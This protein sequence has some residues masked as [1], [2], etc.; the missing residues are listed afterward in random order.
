MLVWIQLVDPAR[1]RELGLAGK[2]ALAV[3]L[4]AAGQILADVL[5]FAMRPLYGSYAEQP[6]R[7]WGL[8]PLEDQRLA[9]LVMMGEQLLTLGTFVAIVLIAQHR[10]LFRPAEDDR[11]VAA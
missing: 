1:R 9:G 3:A 5:I 2:L 10:R 11:R 7:L 8:S 6:D 4:F